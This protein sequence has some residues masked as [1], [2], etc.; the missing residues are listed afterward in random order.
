M[1]LNLYSLF[2]E[3]VSGDCFDLPPLM[4]GAIAYNTGV[5]DSISRPVLTT[6]F[7]TCDNDSILNKL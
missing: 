7:F 3:C 6:A 1:E 4:N 2:V 5:V